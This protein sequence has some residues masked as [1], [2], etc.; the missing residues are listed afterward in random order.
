[1]HFKHMNRDCFC[2]V[3]FKL[4]YCSLYTVSPFKRLQKYSQNDNSK[5]SLIVPLQFKF[6]GKLSVIYRWY[7]LLFFMTEATVLNVTKVVAVVYNNVMTTTL[8]MA[9]L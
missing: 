7:E 6:L 2:V 3:Y 8:V 4:R 5:M 1:M 9:T